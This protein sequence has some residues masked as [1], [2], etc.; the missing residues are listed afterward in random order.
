[1]AAAV[2]LAHAAQGLSLGC[3]DEGDCG[4]RGRRSRSAHAVYGRCGFLRADREGFCRREARR[5]CTRGV[6]EQES[7]SVARV[8]EVT[9]GVCIPAYRCAHAGDEAAGSKFIATPLMQ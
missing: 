2:A 9:P 4:F 8:S 3:G 5:R 7:R 1:M 6:L